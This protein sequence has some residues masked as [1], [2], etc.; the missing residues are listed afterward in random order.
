MIFNFGEVTLDCKILETSNYQSKHSR[1][2]VQKL[3]IQTK[4]RGGNSRKEFNSI[5]SNANKTSIISNKEANNIVK[6]WKIGNYSSSHTQDSPLCNYKI[7]IEEIEPLQ[8]TSLKIGDMIL[9]PY[10]Y[11]EYFQNDN[12]HINA[13]VHVNEEDQKKIKNDIEMGEELEVIRYGIDDQPRSMVLRLSYWSKNE[14]QIK[15]EIRLEEINSK[16]NKNLSPGSVLG[17]AIH[18]MTENQ[19]MTEILMESLV[20]KGIFNQDEI[21]NLYTRM[22]ERIWQKKYELFQVKDIDD[23]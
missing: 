21:D 17:K 20:D 22:S 8:A 16:K 1:K 12:L 6:Y 4:V 14:N 3:K 2:T 7:D 23:D 13:K 10:S 19:A 9:K 5:L 15:H 18:K 11:E